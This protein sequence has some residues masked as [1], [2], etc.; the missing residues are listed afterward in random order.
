VPLGPPQE[1]ERAWFDAAEGA[2]ARGRAASFAAARQWLEARASVRPIVVAFDDIHWA[3]AASLEFL[4]E[5]RRSLDQ[6][7]V[8]ILLFARSEPDTP[9]LTLEVDLVLP[10]APLGDIPSRAIAQRLAPDAPGERIDDIVRRAG[11][12]PFFLE[13]LARDLAEAGDR[14]SSELPAAVELVIQ[15]RLDRLPR[16]GRR[17]AHAASVVGR[18][19][20]RASVRAAVDAIGP[21]GDDV[22]DRALAELERRQIIAATVIAGGSGATP[23]PGGEE[24]YVFHHAL[25]RDVAYAQLDD[26]TRQR[27]HAAL[28]SHL[29]R[30]GAAARRE[31][32]T[33]AAMARHRDAAGDRRGARDAYR[34]AG[35][36]ALELYAYREA[37]ES[38]LRA[39][40]LQDAPDP[41]LAELCGDALFHVNSAAATERF[42]AALELTRDP[43]ARARLY[44]KLGSA[45]AN[46]ADYATAVSSFEQGLALLTARLDIDK[47][48]WPIRVLAA[49]LL[50]SLGWVIGYCIGDH[51]RG[52]PLAERAVALL[53]GGPELLELA[54]AQSRL[55][56]TY[57]RAGRWHDRLR[58]NQRHL[59]IAKAMVD[60]DR[61]LTARI[62]LG[63]NYHSLGEIDV[64]LEHTRA[65][66]ELAMNTGRSAA[67][68]LV[69]NNMG[70]ILT[71]A[72]LEPQARAH[73][74]EGM[75]LAERVGYTRFLTEARG[76]LARLAFRAADFAAAEREARAAFELARAAGSRVDEGIALRLLAGIASEL[77]SQEVSS[78]LASALERLDG[79]QYEMARTWAAEAKHAARS[80]EHER[81][82][83]RR[84]Q[85]VAVFESLGARLDIE[86]LDDPADLR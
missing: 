54:H 69:H 8:A 24:R 45:A 25:T 34:M 19:F 52:V 38:L 43:I 80:G 72:G 36:L 75:R 7:P 53:E 50:G 63:V 82:A 68:A 30:S 35:Q 79:D 14:A 2:A 71:D 65:A 44:N 61:E 39:E 78:L 12:N 59:E 10:L 62:N 37:S 5:L 56:A 23:P 27:V 33:L 20:D 18:E 83:A 26:T 31:P 67:R 55:A 22:L 13:E 9:E 15:A 32:T 85:A 64:A 60:L 70:V 6:V 42:R 76:T 47:A 29:E 77:G 81:A 84:A 48:D 58:C 49:R 51:V 11:G 74:D 3:D 73:L 46:R 57:M 86:R 28:A 1:A 17:L 4:A 16:P 66:L 40:E 21:M 41:K